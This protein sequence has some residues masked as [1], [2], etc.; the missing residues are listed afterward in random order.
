M[1]VIL[2]T[3]LLLFSVNG[4]AFNWKEVT[5]NTVGSSYY[6]DVDNIKKHNRLVYYWVLVDLLEP[7][8]SGA[9]SF[10]D[11][12]ISALPNKFNTEV[13]EKGI[14]ISG[15]QKQRIG[16]ARAL[17]KKSEILILDEATSAL[18]KET[19]DMV[20]MSIN[21]NYKDKTVISISHR[22]DNLKDFDRTFNFQQGQI[23][24]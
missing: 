15:G 22:I 3:T 24:V 7:F 13:G 5:Q 11:K 18:D 19:E 16:I 1:R 14:R 10:I 6:V 17:Y 12:F 2:L 8:D 9:N 20:I 23:I 4:F 21:E